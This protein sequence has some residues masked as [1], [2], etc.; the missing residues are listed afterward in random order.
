[1]RTR[2]LAALAALACA[3][4]LSLG[5]TAALAA[6][7]S[8]NTRAMGDFAIATFAT[9]PVDCIWLNPSVY[10]YAGD[11]LKNPLNGGKP[12]AWSDVAVELR[13]HDICDGSQ[14]ADHVGWVP[15]TA[16]QFA[17]DR[18]KSAWVTNV[19]VPIDAGGGRELDAVLS[20][21]WI[22]NGASSPNHQRVGVG[23]LSMRV[24]RSAPAT[25]FGT[26]AFIDADHDVLADD[27]TFTP[28]FT[29][30]AVIGTFSEL[31]VSQ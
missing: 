16:E 21:V 2:K 5:A 26:L 8:D 18:L 20:L 28:S 7:P 4:S 10:L 3:A 11:K 29:Y 14:E 17:F 27:I 9:E 6:N 22:A 31:I 19:T 23:S 30:D 15:I 1:M 12:G 24:E 13:I 25:M